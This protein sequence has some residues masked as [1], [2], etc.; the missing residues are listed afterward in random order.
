MSTLWR[1]RLNVLSSRDGIRI[2]PDV[3]APDRGTRL[4]R[5]RIT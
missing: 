4:S 3:G 1:V 2:E 5:T